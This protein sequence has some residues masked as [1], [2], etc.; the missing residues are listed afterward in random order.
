MVAKRLKP[1]LVAAFS[2]CILLFCNISF[3]QD[4]GAQEGA[5]GGHEAKEEKLNPSKLILEHVGD[6]HE[7]HF[8]AL[9]SIPLPVILYSSGKGLSVFMSSAFH[10]GEHV[11]NGYRLL[12][13][14]YMTVNKL[15][16]L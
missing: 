6:G 1:L 2:L 11:V 8:G 3:G 14:E 16:G 15:E 4:K 13:D 5:K 12:S 10:H 7:F 9:G